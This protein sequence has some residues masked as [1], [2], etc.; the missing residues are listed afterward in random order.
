MSEEMIS[1]KEAAAQVRLAVR[2]VALYHAAMVDLL[3]ER[4]GETAGR[5][6][7][8]A[9]AERYGK[10]VGTAVR[11][12][13]SAEGKPATIDHYAEDLPRLGF[14]AEILSRDPLRIR[15]HDCPLAATW[16]EMGKESEGAIYCGVD[17]AKYRAYNPALRCTHETHCLRDGTPYCDLRITAADPCEKG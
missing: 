15:I 1:E 8:A 17:R 3:T 14:D 4:L 7:A 2:R 10:I 13:V 11:K 16:R 9:V 5:E 12:R 6:M